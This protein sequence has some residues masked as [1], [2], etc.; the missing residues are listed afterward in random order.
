MS[1][2]LNG[3]AAE[4]AAERWYTDRGAEPVAKRWRSAA[5]EVDLILRDKGVLVFVEVK[6]R[7]SVDAAAYAIS[8]RQWTRITAAAE[9]Y[10]AENTLSMDTDLRFDAALLDRHGNI[11]VIENAAPY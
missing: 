3:L 10:L 4:D 8:A 11:E 7:K 1:R 6:I 9:A 5:G 2:Y